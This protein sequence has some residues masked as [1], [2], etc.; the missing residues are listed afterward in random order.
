M[1]ETTFPPN[2][3]H[4]LISNLAYFFPRFRELP[5]RQK[6]DILFSLIRGLGHLSKIDSK[7]WI[8]AGRGVK[9]YKEN[10]LLTVDQFC[11]IHPHVQISIVGRS[12]ENKGTLS[13]GYN[14]EIGSQT[15][16]NVCTSITIG[17]ESGISWNCEI[18]DNDFHAVIYDDGQP[19][20]SSKPVVIED[21]V[22]VGCN[23]IILKGVTIGHHSVVAA[24]SVIVND[25]PPYS[26]VRGNP[27]RVAMHIQ[28]WTKK[29]YPE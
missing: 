11:R 25:V 8:L 23:S 28:G 24:G 26:L 14:T 3:K 29:P 12:R 18:L 16:I 9:I 21:N 7:G 20:P 15:R 27:A 22:L 1:K 19:R 6:I 2:T 10:G 4:P 17:K 13:I 5:S